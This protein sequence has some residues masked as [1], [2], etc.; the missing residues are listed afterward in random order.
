MSTAQERGHDHDKGVLVIHPDGAAAWWSPLPPAVASVH[1]AVGTGAVVEVDAADPSLVV[2]WGLQ[3][4][5]D[6]QALSG[7]FDDAQLAAHLRLLADTGQDVFAKSA[8]ALTEA[9]VRRANVAAVAQCTHRPVHESA[10]LLDQASADHA[11]GRTTLATSLFQ[12]A[13]PSLLD[14]GEDCL[15]G[16]ITGGA[17]TDIARIAGEAS[18]VLSGSGWAPDVAELADQLQADIEP[19]SDTDAGIL[20]LFDQLE[21]ATRDMAAAHMSRTE[22]TDKEY[23]IDPAAVPARLLAWAGG[24]TRD[25]RMT[26]AAGSNQFVISAKLAASVDERSVELGELLAYAADKNTGELVAVAPMRVEDRTVTATVIYDGPAAELTFGVY[27]A[28]TDVK[29]LR[30]DEL[31]LLLV[32][33]DRRMLDAYQDHRLALAAIHE[34]DVISAVDEMEA[35]RDRHLAEAGRAAG[36]AADL[37]DDYLDDHDVDSDVEVLLQRRRQAITAYGDGLAAG[38]L[39]SPP[40][41]EPLLSELLPADLDDRDTRR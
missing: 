4:G 9:W 20:A 17:A 33:V 36:E 5:G 15:A 18:Q 32:R 35:K 31:G 24:A 10:L 21:A 13:A 30:L 19:F 6:V 37:L 41:A 22:T 27:H 1:V 34:G 39:S 3:A 8:P 38:R 25:L 40:G 14:L 2:G 11:T 28:D 12:M 23:F 29:T 16:Q 7:A 26:N